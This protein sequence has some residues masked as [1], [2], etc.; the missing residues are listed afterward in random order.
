VTF[1]PPKSPH[2]AFMD[3]TRSRY[4]AMVKRISGKQDR[5]GRKYGLRMQVPFTLEE[6]RGWAIQQL[7][8]SEEGTVRCAYCG[9]WLN[10]S[11]LVTDHAVP[12]SRGGGLGLNNL[13]ASCEDC[14]D[15][16]GETRADSYMYLIKC[17]DNLPN[18]DRMSYLGRLK[19]AEKLA[20]TNR[21]NR[22][23]MLQQQKPKEEA[24]TA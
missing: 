10:I 1:K 6:Y 17:L 3:F 2:T 23:R 15:G 4:N 21:M 12:P 19:K 11:T 13:V 8:G 7:Q 9:R 20:A 5:L 24:V 22:V 14:N 18:D 16:K